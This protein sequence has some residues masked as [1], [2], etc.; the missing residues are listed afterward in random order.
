[1]P[2]LAIVRSLGVPAIGTDL[3]G[4]ANNLLLSSQGVELLDGVVSVSRYAHGLIGRLYSGP[5]EVLIGP[6][7]T[8][9]FR[10]ASG[11]VA[12]EGRTVLCV[13]RIMPHKGL[14]RVIA[15]LPPGLSLVIVGRV[16]NEPYYQLLQQMAADKVV[17][18]IHEA[19][20]DVLIGLYR[21]SDLFVRA[22]A[23]RDVYGYPVDKPEVISLTTLE[24]MA[25]GLAAAVSD[26]GSL[27]ELVPDR[28]LGRVFAGHHDL[29]A[30]LHDV[31]AGVWPDP[32]AG[33]L[34]RSH[35]VSRHGVAAIGRR[36]AGFY[37]IVLSRRRQAA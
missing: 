19:D 17:R 29:S 34:A 11:G 4:G 15:A 36:I 10:P 14:D 26:T 33:R 21:S 27:P 28:R 25:C 37:R 7:D 30:I 5:Y 20:D 35:V 32:N 9:R 6:V 16:D 8:D 3:G 22:S 13:S 18:F 12:R 31:V 23:A 2:T 1:M 24:A